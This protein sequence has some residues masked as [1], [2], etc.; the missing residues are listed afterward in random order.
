[1]VLFLKNVMYQPIKDE[2]T[3][4][5]FLLILSFGPSNNYVRTSHIFP[6]LITCKN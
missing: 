1:M 3:L 6:S 5:I 2:M 4:N